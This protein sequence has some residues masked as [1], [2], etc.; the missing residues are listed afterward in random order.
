MDSHPHIDLAAI[1]KN[2]ATQEGFVVTFSREA[3]GAAARR[4]SAPRSRRRAVTSG[5]LLWS[6]IDNRESRD[7][8]QIEVA[9]R[10]PDGSIRVLV[11]IADVDVARAEGLADRSARAREHDVALHR[12]RD[13]PDAARRAVDRR[14]RRCSTA[15][16]ASRSSPR[17]TSRADGAIAGSRRVSRARPQPREAR[18]RGRRR[19]AR[20]SRRAAAR[21]RERTPALGD[22]LRMQ[23][24]AAQRLRRRASSTARSSSRRSRRAPSRRTA[25]SS[26]SSV[27]HKN[28]ARE[29]IEDLMIA[30]NGATARFLEERG[31]RLAPPRRA[32]AEA[33]GPHRRARGGARRDAARP[34]PIAIALVGVPRAT[35]QGRIRRTSPDLS[36]SI[37]K[38]HGPGRVRRSQRRRPTRAATSGSPS[39]TTRTRPRRTAAIARSRHAAPA[40]G[41]ARRRRRRRTPTTSSPRSRRAAPSARTPRARSSARC[42][43]SRPR[44]SCS[45]RI[46]ETFDADRHRRVAEGHVRARCR[47]ARRGPRRPRRAGLDVGDTLRVKL[48]GDRADA[49]ASSTSCARESVGRVDRD[50]GSRASSEVPWR[51][52]RV[53]EGA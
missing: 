18:L 34:S 27:T 37:V 33:L 32:Q 47:S 21:D 5:M 16:I 12:R 45:T 51:G 1:A 4:A 35:P 28:R 2:V 46:G 11:G 48:V 42:A 31:V 23:D 9:E 53:V 7:L 6:S 3:L 26:T 44:R 22:Q 30:A 36:L 29:L 13:V 10:L 24:E 8:D 38:L 20:G 41:G 40:E 43:R 15:R 25:R 49:R 39:T 50:R 52:D 19:V 17:S 14:A